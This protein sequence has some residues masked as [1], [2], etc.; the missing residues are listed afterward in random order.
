M[1]AARLGMSAMK[2]M[3]GL[4]VAFLALGYFLPI[5]RLIGDLGSQ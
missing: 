4:A 2:T 3:A 5:V 1:M